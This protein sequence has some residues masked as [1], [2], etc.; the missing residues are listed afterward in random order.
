MQSY[1]TIPV[2]TA[3]PP[4][5]P[6]PPPLLSL[7]FSFFQVAKPVTLTILLSCWAVVN[8]NVN[9]EE[10]DEAMSAYLVFDEDE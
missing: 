8:I 6:P 4:S 9:D 2:P 1:Y 10:T 7:F 3:G 5:S